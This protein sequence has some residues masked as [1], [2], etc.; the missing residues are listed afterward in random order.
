MLYLVYTR[1]QAPHAVPSLFE[2][3]SLDVRTFSGA[4]AV[5]SVMAKLSFWWG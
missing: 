1:A 2:R 4:P 5:D 3:G